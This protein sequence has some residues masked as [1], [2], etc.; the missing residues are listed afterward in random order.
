MNN[1]Q[2]AIEFWLYQKRICCAYKISYFAMRNWWQIICERLFGLFRSPKQWAHYNFYLLATFWPFTI[3]IT[4]WIYGNNNNNNNDNNKIE[5]TKGI[6]IIELWCW[7]HRFPFK[8]T[9]F[10]KSTLI[11]HTHNCYNL[12]M[13]VESCV[14]WAG[15]SRTHKTAYC[16]T[17]IGI[18]WIVWY[19]QGLRL[20]LWWT[21]REKLWS[22]WIEKRIFLFLLFYFWIEAL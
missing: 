12:Y 21:E 5:S 2:R 7:L 20:P 11:F 8:E 10:I 13:R 1:I 9:I 17:S 19:M 4:M 6:T 18:Q 3:R 14:A 15:V 16:L 22:G